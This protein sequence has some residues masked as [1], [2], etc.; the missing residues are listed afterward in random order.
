MCSLEAIGLDAKDA[1][2]L[3]ARLLNF[4]KALIAS[5]NGEGGKGSRGEFAKNY[6][7]FQ[8]TPLYSTSFAL[9]PNWA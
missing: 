5:L 6:P 7:N 1:E 4:Y 3:V 9:H 8:P 2:A